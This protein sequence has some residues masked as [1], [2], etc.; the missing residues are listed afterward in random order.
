MA[1]TLYLESATPLHRLHPATK[2]G[3]MVALF[4]SAFVSDTPLA[5]APLLATAAALAGASGAL[6][7]V[8]RL[9]A[10]FLT[11][12]T[13]TFL[14]WLA[15]Y[16]KGEVL[17]QAGPLLVRDKS[18]LF[19][20]GMSLKMLSFLTIGVLFLSVTTI[21]E[22]AYSLVRV[23]IP[24]KFGFTLTLAFRLVPAFVDSAMTVVQAQ[25]SRG[26]EF[27]EGGLVQRARRY[28]PIIVPVFIGALRRA[29]GMAMALEARGFQNAV[30]RTSY[31]T[32]AARRADGV[33]AVAALAVAG[34]YSVLWWGGSLAIAP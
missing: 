17:L 31:V 7:N 29:D 23:G 6:M 12:G 5:L 30:K 21:E 26:F 19:A 13:M 8:W 18:L 15:F 24:F 32:F 22:F 25:R 9:R 3:G 4:F 33:A 16:G 10:L 14:A 20:S 34:T 2:L 27:D 11:A 1:L 28:I